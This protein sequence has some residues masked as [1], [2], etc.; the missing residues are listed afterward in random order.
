MTGLIPEYGGNGARLRITTKEDE[1]AW[2]ERN[3]I[4]PAT[5]APAEHPENE[6]PQK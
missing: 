3:G 2:R 5:E 4:A 1:E 6:T